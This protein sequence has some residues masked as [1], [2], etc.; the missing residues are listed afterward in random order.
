MHLTKGSATLLTAALA[1]STSLGVATSAAAAPNNN[2]SEKLRRAVTAEGIIEHLTELEAIADRNGGDRVSGTP[3]YDESVRYV[4]QRL[5][6]AGYQP[7]IQEFDFPFYVEEEPAH[8]ER[9]APT[10]TSYTVDTDFATMTYSGAGDVT[11]PVQAVD[12]T[13]PPG[14]ANTSTSG[15]EAA[16]FTGFVSGSIALV[17]R[18]TCTFATKATNAAAAGASGVVV[19]NEGQSGRTAVVAGT[20]GAPGITIPVVGTSYAIGESLVAAGTEAHLKV[21]TVS[22]T[23]TTANVVAQTPGRTDQVIAAG[24]HLDSVSGTPA[25]NDDGSGSAALLEI[26]EQMAK[27]KPNNAVRFL[28]FGAEEFGLLGSEDYVATR[29]DAELA[30]IKGYLNFDMLGSPNY[31]R[32]V[33]DADATT[34]GTPIPPKSKAIEDVFTSYFGAQGLA[35]EQQAIGANTDHYPFM[36]AGI[37]IGGLTSGAGGIKTPEQAAAFGGTAGEPYDPNYHTPAD[38]VDPINPVVLEQLSD[39]A[40]H[41]I[42]TFAYDITGLG[43]ASVPGKSHGASTSGKPAKPDLT[44]GRSAA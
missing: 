3:G 43:G 26:A 13:I 22:E 6:A 34:T 14:S 4:V 21:S 5:R 18:G 23:R 15:C 10:P 8:M 44:E 17:Q 19:F 30:A 32:F 25:I 39:A 24:A 37:P 7:E 27:V 12:V 35:S 36:E 28:W 9:T 42:I 16:D 29:T 20:L 2:S 11:A 40:A 31:V 41:A 38:R 33:Y 1:V